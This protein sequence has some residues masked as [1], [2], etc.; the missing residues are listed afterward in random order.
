MTRSLAETLICLAS[1]LEMATRA[2]HFVFKACGEGGDFS[3]KLGMHPSFS[4]RP[5]YGGRM[6]LRSNRRKVGISPHLDEPDRPA[7]GLFRLSAEQE[8]GSIKLS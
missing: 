7:M 8:H 3:R 1:S 6:K 4:I 5:W 2:I